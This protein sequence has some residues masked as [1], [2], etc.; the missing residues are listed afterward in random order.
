MERSGRESGEEGEIN[1]EEEKNE[2]GQSVGHESNNEV[3]AYSDIKIL[4]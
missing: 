2:N 1:S 3:Q 4:N